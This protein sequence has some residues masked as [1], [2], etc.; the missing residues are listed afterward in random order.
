MHCFLVT[1]HAAE[2]FDFWHCWLC[3]IVPNLRPPKRCMHCSLLLLF[4]SPQLWY[5][6]WKPVYYALCRI[7]CLFRQQKRNIYPPSRQAK[8]DDF[9]VLGLLAYSFFS[10]FFCR[11]LW[12]V[13]FPVWSLASFSRGAGS[14]LDSFVTLSCVVPFKR[15][16]FLQW[17][18]KQL[19]N[20]SFLWLS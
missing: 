10:F 11:S 17:I 16:S 9:F 15:T 3:S 12:S 20:G 4:V 2:F 5:L 1:D 13:C 7:F 19:G 6:L 18:L 8:L 14:V